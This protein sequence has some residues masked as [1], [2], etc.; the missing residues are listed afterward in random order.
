MEQK[1]IA[2]KKKNMRVN[3]VAK[4]VSALSSPKLSLKDAARQLLD[5]VDALR[6]H[7]K[8]REVARATPEGAALWFQVLEQMRINEVLLQEQPRS[9]LNGQTNT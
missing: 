8:V 1:I 9:V 5:L 7:M 4:R 3:K 2:K 6:A